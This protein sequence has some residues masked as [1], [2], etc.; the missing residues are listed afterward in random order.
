[1]SWIPS[2]VSENGYGSENDIISRLTAQRLRG[3]DIASGKNNP[4]SCNYAISLN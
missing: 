2:S 4:I 3:L 1:M